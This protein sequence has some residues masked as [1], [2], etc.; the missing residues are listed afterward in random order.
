MPQDGR[1]RGL[2]AHAEEGVR[3]VQDQGLELPEVKGLVPLQQV[4]QPPRRGHQEIGACVLWG[5]GGWWVS[6]LATS[7]PFTIST[8]LTVLG[9]AL[10]GVAHV[11]AAHQQQRGLQA[12]V[13]AEVCRHPEDLLGELPVWFCVVLRCGGVVGGW[14]G[15]SVGIYGEGV[16]KSNDPGWASLAFVRTVWAR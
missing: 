2:E 3:L 10:E 13:L 1:Q 5:G 15:R 7:F 6:I 9:E 11:R 12:R 4:L 14:V 8:T 16:M